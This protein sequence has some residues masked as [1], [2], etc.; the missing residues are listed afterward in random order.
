MNLLLIFL[1]EFY[2]V[3]GTFYGAADMSNFGKCAILIKT[4]Q[5][6]TNTAD[7]ASLVTRAQLSGKHYPVFSVYNSN[8]T[9]SVIQPTFSVREECSLN[10]II[11]FG[12]NSRYA[13]FNYMVSNR[14]TFTSHSHSTYIIVVESGSDPVL[15]YTPTLSLPTS[16]FILTIPRTTTIYDIINLKPVYKYFCFSCIH[17]V[18]SVDYETGIRLINDDW[19]YQEWEIHYP[20]MQVLNVAKSGS[21]KMC[22]QI[23]WTK[24]LSKN[25]SLIS[26][27]CNKPYAFWDLVFRSVNP[28]LTA[29]LSVSMD[30][31]VY[32]FSGFFF[33]KYFSKDTYINPW[34][35]SSTHYHASATTYIVYCDCDRRSDMVSID[36]WTTCFSQTVW[37]CLIG[38]LTIP[39]A[40]KCFKAYSVS[41]KVDLADYIMGLTDTI[42]TALRQG[43]F[44][45][46]GLAV[47]SLGMFFIS[48]VFE[49]TLMST[50]V[51]P[52]QLVLFDLAKLAQSEYE[53]LINGASNEEYN[54]TLAQLL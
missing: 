8:N 49:K 23:A 4:F 37:F 40:M 14:Y 30:S 54:L 7:T 53:I 21:I 44:I 15:L 33:Q 6:D 25:P 17:T 47:F 12:P 36:T 35:A 3:A 52:N 11:G 10:V 22:E 39:A 50:L 43:S 2:T 26:N 28:N 20:V 24:W 5:D 46:T 9:F 16:I 18:Q 1:L 34:K 29:Q 27:G 31:S 41:G 38:A 48:A 13:L 45:G 42:A 51:V 19:L 32:G